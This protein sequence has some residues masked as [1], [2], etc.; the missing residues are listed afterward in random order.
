MGWVDRT[1]LIVLGV[2][3]KAV[4]GL[5]INSLSLDG[6]KDTVE[7]PK[8]HVTCPVS[9]SDRNVQLYE[10]AIALQEERSSKASGKRMADQFLLA[11]MT[12]Q[13]M[14]LLVVHPGLPVSPLGGV[15]VRNRI[16]FFSGSD[17][18]LR[19]MTAYATVGGKNNLARVVKR[20]IEFDIHV[21][22]RSTRSN[23]NLVLRQ[24]ITILAPC[25]TKPSTSKATTTST[26]EKEDEVE[27]NTI[28]QVEMSSSAPG[29]WCRVCG[30]YNPI[31]VSSLLAKLFG[32][33]GKIAHGNHVVAKTLKMMD[34]EGKMEGC[35]QGK[36]RWVEMQFRRPMVL[37]IRLGVE[38]GAGNSNDLVHWQCVGKQGKVHV[39]GTV[40][41][42]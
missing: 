19:D 39:T 34:C 32:F 11:A 7:L 27:Y 41:Q 17:D 29:L 35:G 15:N 22:I 30:D 37:P 13:L 5:F 2:A 21:D 4:K 31:H 33:P 12:N 26:E 6:G 38:V 14:L 3:Y 40:G 28:G 24:I 18:T 25:K 36:D 8:L 23:N 10:R 9:I 20:G 16:E 1:V 42:M